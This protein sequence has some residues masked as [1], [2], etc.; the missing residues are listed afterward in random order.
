MADVKQIINPPEIKFPSKKKITNKTDWE[1][2]YNQMDTEQN[3][4][5][6]IDIFERAAD[7]E[8]DDVD[9]ESQEFQSKL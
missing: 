3:G 4:W 7:F 6:F 2:A 9:Y 1:T 8:I 5:N